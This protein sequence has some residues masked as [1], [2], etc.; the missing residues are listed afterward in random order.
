MLA[1]LRYAM[2]ATT[3]IEP[4]L[5][6]VEYNPQFVQAASSSDM[7]VVGSFEMH[8]GNQVCL[9][10]LAIPFASILPKLD[11]GKESQPRTPAEQEH[12]QRNATNLRAALGGAPVAVTVRFE[13]TTLTPSQLLALAPGDVL[14]LNHRVT[15]PL[16]VEAGGTTFAYALAGRRGT[17]LAGLVVGTPREKSV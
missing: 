13:P 16:A 7:M 15:A 1:V 3:G 8:T 2:E 9:A 11:A 12:S 14:P 17:R 5:R 6:T 10:T 4:K